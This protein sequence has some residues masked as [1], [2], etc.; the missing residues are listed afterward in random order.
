MTKTKLSLFLSVAL[1]SLP[2][3]ANDSPLEVGTIDDIIVNN[4]GDVAAQTAA[5]TLPETAPVVGEDGQP[6]EP[7]AEDM[8]TEMVEEATETVEEVTTEAATTIEETVTEPVVE[9][10]TPNIPDAPKMD[11]VETIDMPEM[12]EPVMTETVA[13]ETPM[14]ET[15]EIAEPIQEAIE[16][17]QETAIEK[18]QAPAIEA[19]VKAVQE[20]VTETVPMVQP[21]P[22]AAPMMEKP[23]TSERV[24]VSPYIDTSR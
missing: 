14:V 1:L 8:A 19:P 15:P 17:V 3:C 24:Y 6:L 10:T 9:M 5:P 20:A 22:E 18:P 16:E 7:M 11:A 13:P 4:R 23:A 2:A 21:A 12:P